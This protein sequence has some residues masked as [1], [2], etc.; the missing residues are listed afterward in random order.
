MKKEEIERLY[1]ELIIPESKNPFHFSKK[2]GN[3]VLA[4]NPICGDKF[5][6]YTDDN[7]H[8]HGH[9]CALSKASASLMIKS[10]VTLREQETL[11]FIKNFITSVQTGQVQDSLDEGL[12]TLVRLKQFEGRE[13]CIL[14]TWEAVLNF[15]EQKH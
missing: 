14:L 5:N 8:F 1:K 15:L 13:E 6:I 3:K 7:F 2:E 10:L 4:Y 12:S 11:G 9:G